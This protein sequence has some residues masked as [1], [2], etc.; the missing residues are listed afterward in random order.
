MVIEKTSSVGI[1]VREVYTFVSAEPQASLRTCYDLLYTL[2]DTSI[3]S[4]KPSFCRLE[5]KP[6]S[7]LPGQSHSALFQYNCNAAK[8]SCRTLLESLVANN[9]AQ[10]P[11]T[12]SSFTYRTPGGIQSSSTSSPTV[13]QFGELAGCGKMKITSHM[14]YTPE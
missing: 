6:H 8:H 10:H 4:T 14:P 3:W 2:L 13:M 11:F 5:T 7:P 1:R 9:L 12:I